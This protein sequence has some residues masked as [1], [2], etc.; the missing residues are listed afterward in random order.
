MYLIR[1]AAERNESVQ[2]T[3]SKKLK[4]NTEEDVPENSSTEFRIINFNTV[5]TAIFTLVKCKK[6]DGICTVSNSNESGHG[7]GAPDGVDGILKQTLDKAVAYGKDILNVA[8]CE[9]I[10]MEHTKSIKILRVTIEEIQCVKN[11]LINEKIKPISGSM[12][13]HHVSINFASNEIDYRELSCNICPTGGWC[14]PFSILKS[15]A[16]TVAPQETEQ[17]KLGDWVKVEYQIKLYPGK[18]INMSETNVTASCTEQ[19]LTE[20]YG[21]GPTSRTFAHLKK[22]KFME[23]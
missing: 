13:I 21:I 6:C 7:K 18:V 1:K 12:K 5:F 3:S 20:K 16:T 14:S 2:S 11:E 4:Q 17:L 22:V 10:L 19:P 23:C 8:E 9:K 15:P